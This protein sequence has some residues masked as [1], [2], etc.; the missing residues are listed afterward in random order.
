VYLESLPESPEGEA[1]MRIRSTSI[2]VVMLLS[3]TLGGAQSARQAAVHGSVQTEK[4]EAV[5]GASVDIKG[6]GLSAITKVDGTFRVE[7]VKPGRYWI[8]VTREGLDPS[9]KAVTLGA[10]EDRGMDVHLSPVSAAVSERRNSEIDSL[11]RAF[12]ERLKSSLDGVFLTR[13]DITR[14]REPQLGAML[15]DYLVQMAPRSG[16]RTGANCAPYESWVFQQARTQSRFASD[17][18]AYPYISVNGARPFRGR[19]LYEF[20]PAD[21]EALEF[22][23]GA[24]PSFGYLTSSAQCGL[25]ILWTK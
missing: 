12:A 20:D 18:N 2:G 10:D 15:A 16:V 23:R 6:S 19:A 8:T 1:I 3:A 11:Y 24:G 25:I 7:G 17:M 4:G 21:V 9:R 14:S 13:D 22:Y 5:E